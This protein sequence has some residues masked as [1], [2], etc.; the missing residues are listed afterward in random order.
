[1]I[2]KTIK[3]ITFG[4]I[5]LVSTCVM[6]QQEPQFTQYMYNPTSVNPAYAGARD[7][8]SIFGHY[9]TQWVGV[10]GAPKTVNVSAHTPLHNSR[11]G[12]G[13]SL[14]NDALGAM[15]ESAVA[16]D[17]SYTIDLSQKFRLAFGLKGSA[18]LLNVD[19]NKLTIADPTEVGDNIDNKF[20]P[21]V[22]AGLFLYS[23]KTF[24]GISAPLLLSATRYDDN[25]KSTMSQKAH[26]YATAG[27]VF[28]LS[29]EVKFKPAVITKIVS[30]AP[31]QVDATANF[32]LYDKLTIGGAYRWDAAFSGLI[33]Y[34]F[35]DQIFVGYS[36]DADTK[37]LANYSSGSHEFLLR[38]ELFNRHNR[39]VSPR[40]F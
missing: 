35:T 6:A 34:Q 19:Y 4:A 30:G 40:F 3:T 25:I 12:L 2:L 26:I 14:Q 29:R 28:E 20:T 38:F 27:H 11:L 31:L 1:M 9:R 36:Y 23:D 16:V 37:P 5:L 32:L 17:L 13:L 21:N 15:D 7:A 24:V 39:V 33:G 18:N 8:L 10:E 22:G